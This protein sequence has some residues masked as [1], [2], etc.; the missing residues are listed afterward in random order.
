MSK[1][2]FFGA[3]PWGGGGAAAAPPPQKKPKLKKK[4]ILY[5]LYHQKFYVF[6]PSA[7]I[8]H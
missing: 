1:L 2:S 7:K 8:S 3:H 6:Y 5:I 4:Q